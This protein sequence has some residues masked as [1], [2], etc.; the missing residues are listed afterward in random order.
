MGNVKPWQV[1]LI[2]AAFAVLGFS[3]WRFGFSNAVK[4]P[5]SILLV[6]VKTGTLYDTRK[7][8]ARGILLPARH[9]E[10]NERTLFP[11]EKLADG[12]WVIRD[13]YASL[14]REMRLDNTVV[15]GNMAVRVR[16]DPPV[17]YVMT[18]PK[19]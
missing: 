7:G 17:R 3:I 14:F 19:D 10:T 16:S 2:V 5:D 6:D 13:R 4:Q 15:D 9:P 1:V 12:S 18:V 11:V 8:Q